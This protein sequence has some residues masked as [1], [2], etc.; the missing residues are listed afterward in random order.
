MQRRSLILTMMATAGLAARPRAEA[1]N[2]QG[3]AA[4]QGFDPVAYFTRSAPTRGNP[5]IT[6]S[7]RGAEWRFAS[8]ANR[9]AFLAEPERYAPAFGG[10]CAYAVSEG[11]TASIDP[12]AW[13][14]EGGRLYLNYSAR[15]QRSWEQ[16]IP[17]R[18]ARAD[19][20]WP[21]LSQ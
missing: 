18:I 13:R 14:I 17:G 11:Y 9:A 7:W 1:I 5:A 16:D 15:I 3:G 4:I 12:R 2:L 8:E 19:A 10:F 20:N 21:R 6:A